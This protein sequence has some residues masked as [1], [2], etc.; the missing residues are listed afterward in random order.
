M[1][2]YKN[3]KSSNRLIINIFEKGTE[4]LIISFFG[5]YYK[6]PYYI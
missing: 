3:Y 4:K 1:F 6:P 2:H 5:S